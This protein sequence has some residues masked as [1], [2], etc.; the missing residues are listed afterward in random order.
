MSLAFKRDGKSP[1]PFGGE[2]LSPRFIAKQL[3]IAGLK[4]P[5]PFGGEGLSPSGVVNHCCPVAQEAILSGGAFCGALAPDFEAP[6]PG[7]QRTRLCRDPPENDLFEL[8]TQNWENPLPKPVPAERGEAS[9][10]IVV[11]RAVSGR[12]FAPARDPSGGLL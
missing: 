6:Q 10:G 5:M 12:L 7:L 2:G 3:K 11:A 9:R 8:P 1:M 4:S